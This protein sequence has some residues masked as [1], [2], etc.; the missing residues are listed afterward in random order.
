[1]EQCKSGPIKRFLSEFK[2]SKI[3]TIYKQTKLA[4]KIGLSSKAFWEGIGRLEQCKV[5][6]IKK[7]FWGNSKWSKIYTNFFGGQ[8]AK[9]NKKMSFFHYFFKKKGLKYTFLTPFYNAGNGQ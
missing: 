3:S 7:G 1:M 5:G 2:G 9:D 8:K 6:P 4:K